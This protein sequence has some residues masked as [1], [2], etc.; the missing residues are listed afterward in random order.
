MIM[1]G[2]LPLG[3]LKQC[4]IVFHHWQLACPSRGSMRVARHYWIS[5]FG[6]SQFSINNA[7]I[8]YRRKHLA[9]VGSTY[10]NI[11]GSDYRFPF[12]FTQY[13]WVL[14]KFHSGYLNFIQI[15]NN[16]H[17]FYSRSSNLTKIIQLWKKFQLV[18]VSF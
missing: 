4:G 3:L 18:N 17:Q 12:K 2:M 9:C 1:N 15:L 16:I 11:L 5:L 6:S 14:M 10:P 13:C 7:Y 8:I